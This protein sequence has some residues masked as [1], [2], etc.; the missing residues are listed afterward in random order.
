VVA[1]TVVVVAGTVVVVVVVL[2]VVVVVAGGAAAQTGTV[3]TLLS[4]VTAA[5]RARSRPVTAARVLAST[6]AC[7]RIVPAT[8]ESVLSVAEL[9]TCQKTLQ[10]RPGTRTRRWG[11]PG[12]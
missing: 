8:T 9:P 7:A 3:M 5:V 6:E 11:R 12:R 4:R 1:G 10:R 2:V